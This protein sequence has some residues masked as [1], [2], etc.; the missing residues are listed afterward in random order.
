MTDAFTGWEGRV[1][2][3]KY[4]LDALV[5]RG[6][7]GVVFRG[8]HLTLGQPIAVKLLT[9]AG[10][11]PRAARAA[12]EAKFAEEGS[13]LYT[14]SSESPHVVRA[15][16]QGVEID[17]DAVTPYLVMEWLEGQSLEQELESRR[18]RGVGPRSPREAFELLSPAAE[19]LMVAHALGV[20]HRDIKPANLF[21]S[22]S[23]T[24]R[25]SLKVLDFGIAKVA[26]DASSLTGAMQATTAALSP[27]TILYGAPEQFRKGPYGA[28]GPWTDVFALG[29]VFVELITG[30]PALDGDDQ[31]QVMMAA[32]D[33]R[34]RPTPRA[35]GI[36]VAPAV[37]AALARAL[38]VDPRDRY[39]DA[40]GFWEALRAALFDAPAVSARAVSS[41]EVFA[42]TV[43]A[44]GPAPDLPL[45]APTEPR[46][47]ATPPARPP[48]VATG[49]AV[50]RTAPAAA[51]Q[52]GPLAALFAVV[53]VGALGG[54]ALVAVAGPR[55]LAALRSA[56]PSPPAPAA[57]EP[58]VIAAP[59]VDV[60]ACVTRATAS[61]EQARHPAIHA[62]DGR[63]STAWNEGAPGDGTGAWVEAHLRPDTFVSFVEVSGGWAW[64]ADNGQTDLWVHN[65]SFRVMRVSWDTG[66]AD[67]S[68]DR[69]TDRGVKKRVDVGAA[70]G[71]IRFTALAVDRGRFDDLVLDDVALHGSSRGGCG[72]LARPVAPAPPPALACPVTRDGSCTSSLFVQLATVPASTA[73]DFDF[74]RARELLAGSGDF[75]GVRLVESTK[76]GKRI[77]GAIVLNKCQADRLVV[78]AQAALRT[79][80]A[81]ACLVVDV[82]REI[83][84][85]P[86]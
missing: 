27:F 10:S 45:A 79:N 54:V 55:I 5:G 29:L 56:P 16:D 60:T 46:V 4:R 22:R 30:A 52:R 85:Q 77:M 43:A 13:L 69:A 20:A 31:V 3:G 75:S 32:T 62:F 66:E 48:A 33:P 67:V 78:A 8:R 49:P 34:Q 74:P 59:V 41:R 11:L 7:F 63:P 50:A 18:Q 86:L 51:P 26:R 47:A 24:G 44:T 42:A 80:P 25:V 19:A 76:N 17:G 82:T 72:P 71:T 38:A 21:L 68:F 28:T 57:A 70:T 23:A 53:A 37:E 40:R 64:R 39:A 36:E 12:F 73:P 15:V 83:A 84:R 9:V 1:L 14:L 65:N 81:S 61:S 6:G 35:K 2:A 58:E